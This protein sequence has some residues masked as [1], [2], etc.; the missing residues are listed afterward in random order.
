MTEAWLL[1]D[2]GAIR[3][4]AGN[5]NGS[6]PLHLPDLHS[7]ERIPDPKQVLFAALRA[8]SGLNVRR[9]NQ[10]PVHRRVHRIPDYIQDYSPLAVLPAFQ[11]LQ[12]DIASAVDSLR[13]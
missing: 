5:P 10:I 9:R 7:V 4:A 13:E 12:S 11:S 8:A 1:F 3:S 6:E 2:E